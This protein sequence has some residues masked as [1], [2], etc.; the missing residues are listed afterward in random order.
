MYYPEIIYNNKFGI[1]CFL[2]LNSWESINMFYEFTELYL[3]HI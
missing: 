1:L 2:L 3:I